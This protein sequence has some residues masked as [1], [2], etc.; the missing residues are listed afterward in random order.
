MSGPLTIQPPLAL[1][2]RRS[3]AES[4][5]LRRDKPL[6][7][8]LEETGQT[9]ALPS[10]LVAVPPYTYALRPPATTGARIY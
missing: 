4:Q 9:V 8:R 6:P 5:P 3:V 1:K 10:S 7:D 2:G